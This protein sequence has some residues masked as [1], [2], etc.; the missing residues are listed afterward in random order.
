MTEAL[1]CQHPHLCIM[2]H[3]DPTV[4]KGVPHS[5]CPSIQDKS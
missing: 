4:K 3:G 5:I 1:Q 2:L